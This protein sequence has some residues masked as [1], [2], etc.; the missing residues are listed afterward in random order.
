[1]PQSSRL[2][3]RAEVNEAVERI[4]AT[5]GPAGCVERPA[6]L[7]P[8]L[9]D[10]RGLYRGATPLLARPSS[11]AEVSRVLAICNELGVPVVP[12][13]GNTS[14]CGGAT[15]HERGDEIVMSLSRMNR[16]RELDAANFSITVEAGCLL[17]DVQAAA[18][19][20]E[21][22]FPLSLGSEGSCQIGGNLSTNA[23]GL[24]ALRYGVARELALGLEVVLADGRVLDGLTSLRKDNTGYDLRDLFIGAEGTLGVITAAS[25]K[26]FPRPRTIET[27][28]L[29]VP[30]LGAAVQLLARLRAA[31]G[32]LVTSFEYLPHNAVDLAARHIPGVVAPFERN[33]AGYVLCEVSTARE[34]SMLRGLL[35][36]ELAT[37]MDEGFVLDAVLAESL[38]Q[39]DALWRLRESVPEAQRTE[40]ASIKHDVSV[41]VAALPHFAEEA[42]AAVLDI[43]PDGRMVAYGHVGDGNLHFNVSVPA[44]GDAREFLARAPAIHEAVYG[45]V[46]RYRGSISAEHGIGR[47]KRDELARQKAAVDLEVMRALKRALDPKGIMN[48][49]KVLPDPRVDEADV[50]S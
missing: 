47:M 29:A 33:Y 44:G 21:R 39:R 8:Y 11:T 5:L 9:T 4:R 48:P 24:N 41:P 42:T 1:M 19:A 18:A 28:F 37:A 35:E 14:Y 38:A 20:G 46:R 32:D 13:G 10:F 50:E 3:S 15:P 22:Y 30:G 6:D 49:G 27:A 16:V 12:H 31:S 7:E 45:I 43:V 2:A 36:R 26:L 25:L 40:G 23:G 17:A 34:D